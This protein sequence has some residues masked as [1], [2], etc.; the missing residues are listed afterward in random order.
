MSFVHLHTHSEYSLLDGAA[1]VDDL[2][3]RARE[4][5]MP[6]LAITDHGVMFGAAEFYRKA[7]K[8][9]VK[10]IIGCE[11][12]FTPDSRLD[13]SRKPDLYHLL[14][15]AK[16]MTGY[17]NLMAMVSA[18]HLEGFYYKP[19]VDMELLQQFS[20]GLI[21]TSACMVGIVSRSI[22]RGDVEEATEWARRYAGVF[23]PGD[24]YL[25]MQNQGIT[26]DNGVTQAQLN[27]QIGSIA[28][29]LGLPVV[30]TNDI[31]YVKAEDCSAQ[32]TLQ[33]IQTGARLSD[34]NRMRFSADE[35]FLK[36]AEEMATALPEHRAAL[37]ATL[38]IAERCDV[39][40]E[41]D[42]II[43]PKFP[44]PDDKPE[45][46]ELR[47]QCVA[48]LKRRFGDPLPA[49]VAQRRESE[50]EV[51][52]GKG[53]AAYF[54][55]VADF[56]RWAKD[57]GIRVGPGRG[58]AAGSIISY[59]LGIT[60]LDPL[61]H[62][63]LFER[64]L[65]PERTEMPDIDIDFDD[66]RRPE[67]IEYVRQKYG[68]DRVAQVITFGTMK[69]KAA[70]R[71]A[72]RVLGFPFGVPD[73]VAK[74]I[75]DR[76]ELSKKD[77]AERVTELAKA[78]KDNADLR[79]EYEQNPDA[80]QILDTALKIEGLTRGAGVHAAAVVICRD[81]LCWYT[82]VK[83]DTKGEQVITQYEGT[84][85][86][87]LGL[88]KM[89]FLGLRT[90]TVI[91]GAL[92]AIKEN[93]GVDI[94]I[95][96]IPKDDP[97]TFAMLQRADTAGVFQLESPGMKRTLRDLKPTTM[98][99]IIAVVALF[100]PGPMDSI[101]DFIARKHGR[102]EVTYY[103]DRLRPILEE[104]YGAIVYQ[105]QVMRISMTMAG[106]TAA[107]A[108]KLRKG[109]GK[110]IAEI[111]DAMKPKFID[112]AAEHGYER[113]TAQRVWDDIAK[114]AEYAFNKSHAA[115]YGLIAYQTAY[116]KAHYPREYMAAV[117]NS[118]VGKMEKVSPYIVECERSGIRVLPPDVNTSGKDF[119][120]VGDDIRFGLTAVRN[121]GENV[122][123]AILEG[124]GD[125]PFEH[126]WDFCTRVDMEKVNR[127][128]L[129]ALI[130]AGA[131]DTSGYPRRQLMAQLDQCVDGAL[132]RQR[133][134]AKNQISMFEMDGAS[135][136]GFTEHVPEPET[137]E[138][139]RRTLLAFEKEML[140]VYV[141][142]HPLRGKEHLIE[143]ARSMTIAEAA[144][145]ADGE[146]ANFAG[147]V[148]SMERRPTK[149]GSM[150][151]RLVIEDFEGSI[152][153]VLFA[154]AYDRCQQ[155]LEVDRIVRLTAKVDRSGDRDAQLMIQDAELLEDGGRYDVR[156]NEFTLVVQ[157]RA[158]ADGGSGRLRE[159]LGR[160][161]GSDTVFIKVTSG[162]G[163]RVLRLP[164][165][166]AVDGNDGGLFGELKE[167]FGA[168]CIPG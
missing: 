10:P 81:P 28:S 79:R 156:P 118:Y 113:A 42:K 91:G 128:T 153:C 2:V 119:T 61:E 111:V 92:R 8:A 130:K 135:D 32:D 73:R 116:L 122:V 152:E 139:D 108:D 138:W 134:K 65:N 37:D 158:L 40:L 26:A 14:L 166:L 7:V 157:E 48:G 137:V 77:K 49:E 16:N 19:R 114:F 78:L 97:A 151:A 145:Q 87:D 168:D 96:D 60:A 124:R 129:E 24:F 64:F 47:D 34:T 5:E 25:E 136:H 133:D 11:V 121:V 141:S 110:K 120:V 46:E 45:A 95:D 104:T 88:L 84:L 31:H 66:E 126:M 163:V 27:A 149:R 35:F 67:V 115:A 165:D 140:G 123:D 89:D 41:F 20:E 106:F 53:L 29:E 59:A 17:R 159:I 83:R 98:A 13:K 3:A 143:N 68:E 15:L 36:T 6:A 127:R 54:L 100:R 147:M 150:F 154:P 94:D 131:F 52:N 162:D 22:E 12:Y 101:P 71:D 70:V 50:L 18:S 39:E 56:V 99:D 112:G 9:G 102:A 76:I 75:P 38:E 85:V 90:L 44:L 109:M 21:G 142:D 117:L 167:S 4:L 164:P 62:G 86:A 132:K 148:T 23:A 51:I 144:N 93:H 74:L 72:G 58:S 43:L 57:N 30:G 103:D 105:E 55:I 161:P 125:E 82:P 155:L 69:S 146:V 160:H 63:L 33:C 107:E 80:K 1:R